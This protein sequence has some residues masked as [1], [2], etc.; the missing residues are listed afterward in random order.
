MSCSRQPELQ[1]RQQIDA[2]PRDLISPFGSG[3]ANRAK[4]WLK[5][6]VLKTGSAFLSPMPRAWRILVQ[7][8]RTATEC[9]LMRPW[10]RMNGMG[11]PDGSGSKEID[12]AIINKILSMLDCK[13][14]M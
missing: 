4:H 6:A 8:L 13:N 1:S 10:S 12:H 11:S 7:L 9:E 3:Q 5:D 2:I 14:L